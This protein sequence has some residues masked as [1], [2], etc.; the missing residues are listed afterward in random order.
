[1]RTAKIKTTVSGGGWIRLKKVFDLDSDRIC[2]SDRRTWGGADGIYVG[3]GIS[4]KLN[5]I[6][7]SHCDGFFIPTTRD[8]SVSKAQESKFVSICSDNYLE[9]LFLYRNNGNI[10][11]RIATLTTVIRVACRAFFNT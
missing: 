8:I 7:V 4:I 11:A 6:S 10:K 3:R 2:C 1:M 5:F 9:N